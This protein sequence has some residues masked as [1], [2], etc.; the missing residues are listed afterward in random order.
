MVV[1]GGQWSGLGSVMI[2]SSGQL[3]IETLYPW[4]RGLSSFIMRLNL[5]KDPPIAPL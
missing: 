5:D 1:G 3:D 4:G 2:F